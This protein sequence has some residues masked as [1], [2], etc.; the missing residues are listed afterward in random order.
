M[1]SYSCKRAGKQLGA[2]VYSAY[3]LRLLFLHR[4]PLLRLLGQQ[5]RSLAVR[6]HGFRP[7]GYDVYTAYIQQNFL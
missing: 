7:C 4:H 1:E 6:K 5:Q 2:C 3:Q